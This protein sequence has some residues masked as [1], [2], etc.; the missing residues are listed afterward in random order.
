MTAKQIA[1]LFN[2]AC[3]TVAFWR[4]QGMPCTQRR[5]VADRKSVRYDYNADKIRAWFQTRCETARRSRAIRRN[6]VLVLLD[7]G[8]TMPHRAHESDVGYDVTSIGYKLFDSSGNAIDP[9]D[10]ASFRYIYTVVVDTG[11]HLRPPVGYYFELVPNSRIAKTPFLMCNSPG[12]IDPDYRGSI[13]AC[14]R[15]GQ[16][17]SVQSLDHFAPGKVV[18]QL[19]LRRRES[20]AF[21]RVDKLSSTKRGNGGF[22]STAE[23]APAQ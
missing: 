9:G 15:V 10:A 5:A 16:G 17:A 3:S 6:A 1:N 2:V 14:F 13:K 19:I 7:E 4:R 12:I 21:V 8:A 22:G 23:Q 11:V 18:G 20:M